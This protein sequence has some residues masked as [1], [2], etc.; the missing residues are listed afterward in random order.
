MYGCISS[1]KY[2]INTDD[3]IKFILVAS[4]CSL[5]DMHNAIYLFLLR[6]HVVS[7]WHDDHSTYPVISSN[8]NVL[9]SKALCLAVPPAHDM[10]GFLH[11]GYS[12]AMTAS[13]A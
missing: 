13:E 7:I 4:R 3:Y 9:K 5:T 8:S 12:W 10:D 1:A 2:F 6:H 11:P